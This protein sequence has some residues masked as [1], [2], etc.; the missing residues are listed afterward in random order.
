[1]NDIVGIIDAMTRTDTQR[2]IELRGDRGPNSPGLCRSGTTSVGSIDG[3]V[4]AI[5]GFAV[6]VSVRVHLSNYD[7]PTHAATLPM[8]A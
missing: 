8:I 1:M 7:R 2:Y 5:A 4:G 6:E 3:G